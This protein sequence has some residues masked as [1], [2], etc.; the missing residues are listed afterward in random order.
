MNTSDITQ[1]DEQDAPEQRVLMVLTSHTLLGETGQPTGWYVPEAAHPW[2]EF[3][4]AGIG[5]EWASPAGGRGRPYGV[6]MN[7][8]VQSDFVREFGEHGPDTIAA[9]SIDSKRYEAIFYVGGHG[10]MW[11]FPDNTALAASAGEIYAGGGIVAAVCHG[12]AGVINIIDPS[13]APL[14]AGRRV[15]AFT[16]DEE[17]AVG[18]ADTVPFLLADALSAKGA[19]HVPAINFEPNVI[20]DG[21]LITGQNPASA[22]G[23]ASAVVETLTVASQAGLR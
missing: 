9:V 22:T 2:N 20:T 18:L 16:N 8:A 7:D 12:P 11:D 4:R 23:V 3:R 5:V 17:V 14:A 6:D 10:T 1:W 15:A 19:I 13:G 21:R